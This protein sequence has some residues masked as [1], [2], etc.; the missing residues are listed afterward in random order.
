MQ[1]TLRT[2]A[3][4]LA[5]TAA[6]ASAFWRLPCMGDT[7]VARMDPLVNPGTISDHAHIVH[8]GGNF[9]KSSTRDTLLQSDC[10]SCAV[11]QDK[12]SYWAPALYFVHDNGAAELVEE[13][14]GMLVYY[15]LNGD[16]PK[17]FPPGFRMLAGDK[18]QR[19]FTGPFPDPPLSSWSGDE[20]SQFSLSQKALGFNCLNYDAPAEPS[21]YRHFLPEKSFLDQNCIDGVRF[22]L[23]FP[24]CWNGKDLDSEDHKSH[25]AY[26]SLVKDGMCPE[27]FETRLVS[28]FYETIWNTYAFKDMPGKFVLA[29]GDPTGCGYHADF[30]EAWEDGVLESAVS[31]CTN[32]SG[33]VEDCPVFNLQDQNSQLQCKFPLPVDLQSED[34]KTCPKG[35]PGGVKITPGPAYAIT[36]EIPEIP[37]IPDVI[38]EVPVAND[39]PTVRPPPANP[40][41]PAFFATG[42]PDANQH[43]ADATSNP[44]A[45]ATS[46]STLA[47][48]TVKKV[49]VVEKEVTVTVDCCAT[50][51]PTADELPVLGEVKRDVHVHGH[52]KRGGKA[53]VGGWF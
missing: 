34:Y 35:I 47:D 18:N 16:G 29:N 52:A 36:P 24:S 25:V 44:N 42:V 4:V 41:A 30:I 8:G 32:P 17:A 27:G 50:P 6:P 15:L 11:K 43:N 22:E 23:M 7:G 49:V 1:F 10:T 53:G 13:V 38:P 3:A 31:Q 33:L 28:L 37:E 39:K 12:S 26:P 14:G 21:L 48:G 40:E 19:N 9:G 5:A 2:A 46:Y 45:I 20:I 51:V